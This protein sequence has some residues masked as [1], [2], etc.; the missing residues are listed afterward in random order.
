M[1][2]LLVS[3][4][5]LT[6]LY[7]F[8]LRMNVPETL[9]AVPHP[10]IENLKVYDVLRSLGDSVSEHE[11]NNSIP[12]ASAI[13]GEEI[14]FTGST[15]G[16]NGTKTKIQSKLFKCWAC[17]NTV[18]EE[19]DITQYDPEARLRYAK[20]KH[21][22]FLQGT[23]VYGIVNRKSFYNNDYYKKYGHELADKA[24]HNL[25]E[26]IQLC[27]IG[28]S[29]GRPLEDWEIESVL[30][31]FWT[32]QYKLSDLNLSTQEKEQIQR[33]L[34]SGVGKTEAIALLHSKYADHS[35]AHF[36]LPPPDRKAGYGL[37]GR[38]SIGKDVYTLSCLH[39]HKNGKFAYYFLDTD[40]LS[41]RHLRYHFPRFTNYS[42]YQVVCWGTAP[43][44][45]KKFYMPQ[46][47]RER[48]SPQLLEDLRAYIES[49]KMAK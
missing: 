46:Y 21:L 40:K 25:R 6:G 8:N 20:E 28:C 32:L 44:P 39:C 23:T 4:F 29:Q 7:A 15:T 34:N 48:M 9:V 18:V 43:L 31:F 10:E 26:A 45:G 12:Y 30:G 1:R 17:H 47:T 24:H 19:P 3:L 11:F 22:P 42:T 16:P 5:I 33:A 38:P 49:P 14:F 35:P 37:Q 2:I 41:L 36:L 13:K 27:A